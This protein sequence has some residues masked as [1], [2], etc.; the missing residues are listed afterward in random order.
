LEVVGLGSAGVEFCL[1]LKQQHQIGLGRVGDFVDQ[2]VFNQRTQELFGR[3][4]SLQQEL[5]ESKA[6]AAEFDPKDLP[7]LI[8]DDLFAE[9]KE[10]Y[11][12]DFAANITSGIQRAL[13]KVLPQVLKERTVK[14]EQPFDV[15]PLGQAIDARLSEF[16]ED[17]ERRTKLMLLQ[18]Q[19][20]DLSTVIESDGFKQWKE[21]K[22]SDVKQ[23]IEYS[24]DIFEISKI[25]SDYKES[26]KA[27]AE[28][29]AKNTNRLANAIPLKTASQTP[30]KL[31]SKTP[32]QIFE[33][34]FKSVRGAY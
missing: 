5:R 32:E 26:L 24:N 33:E 6:K 22:G 29:T 1:G 17:L 27:K 23:V 3:L 7:E 16:S 11:G 12:D 15:A 31:T 13:A 9:L 30:V 28:K 20:P 25:L 21:T 14:I 10:D 2:N 4:G 34:S 19:H 18:Q 8:A